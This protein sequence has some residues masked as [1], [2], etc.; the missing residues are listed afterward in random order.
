MRRKRYYRKKRR[1]RKRGREIPY[2]YKNQVY[3]RKRPQTGSGVL[4]KFL[5][6]LLQNVGDLIGL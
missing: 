3:L 6:Y 5:A 1:G 2:I 4:S